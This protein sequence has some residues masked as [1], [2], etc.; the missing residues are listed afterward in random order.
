MRISN[1]RSVEME[2]ALDRQAAVRRVLGVLP[3]ADDPAQVARLARMGGEDLVRVVLA[4]RLGQA[5][6]VEE[7]V[8]AV[9][10]RR[11]ACEQAVKRR[12]GFSVLEGG[13]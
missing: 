11:A 6:T 7:A 1:E 13:Q 2:R 8:A 10:E 4:L 12:A 5:E 9:E 3:A